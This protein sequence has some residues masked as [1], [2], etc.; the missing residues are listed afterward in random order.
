MQM[1]THVKIYCGWVGVNCTNCFH[2]GLR[3]S[4]WR[5]YITH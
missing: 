5:A 1:H 4:M 3:D 2:I